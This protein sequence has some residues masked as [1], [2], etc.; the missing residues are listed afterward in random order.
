MFTVR[1]AAACLLTLTALAGCGQE[2]TAN[3]PPAPPQAAQPVQPFAGLP[4]ER[5]VAPTLR[6]TSGW[7]IAEDERGVVGDDS[8]E[9]LDFEGLPCGTPILAIADGWAVASY[10]SG[11]VRGGKAAFNP[12]D[13]SNPDT[14]WR[15]PING[16]EGFLGYAGLFVELQTNVQVPG[17]QNAVAQYFHLGAVNPSIRWLDPV[18]QADTPTW[19][20]K[21]IVNWYPAGISQTQGDIRRIATPVKRGDV[22]GWMGDTGINFGYNDRFDPTSHTVLPRNRLAEPPWDPQGAGVTTPIDHACQLHLEFYSGRDQA[23]SK[24]GRFDGFD[25]Y[26]RITGVPGTPSYSNPDN[27]R[28]GVFVMG[29]HPIF[30]RDKTGNPEYAK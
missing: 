2:A 22:L 13:P 14:D 26:D 5:S 19:D 6:M 9:A 4:F 28:P 16:H 24:I 30:K 7:L 17:Y 15:D 21:Q 1:R 27:P 23:G 3:P 29:P 12:A 11:A 25:K 18:R 20:G 8:H 10:Q